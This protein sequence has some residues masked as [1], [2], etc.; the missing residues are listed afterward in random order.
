MKT[1]HYVIKDEVQCVWYKDGRKCPA[2][3]KGE[4]I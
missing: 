2:V 3:R 4:C 1:F